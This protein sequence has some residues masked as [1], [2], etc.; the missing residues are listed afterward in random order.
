MKVFSQLLAC[1]FCASAAFGSPQSPTSGPQVPGSAPATSSSY[2]SESYIVER[3][4]KDVVFAADG[5]G[6]E[7]E[8]MRVRILSDA[9]LAEFGI[10]RLPYRSDNQRLDVEAS[11]T[12]ANGT[13]TA[14]PLADIQD[15]PS[16]V[17]RCTAT[18]VK[19]TSLSADFAS[20][21][22]SSCGSD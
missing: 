17:S 20:A 1:L 15:L 10:L 22:C 21:A 3:L 4:S 5:T 6:R 16:D 11:V 2:A 13:V 9:A 14:T 12:A 18:T 7:E 8:T 19:S